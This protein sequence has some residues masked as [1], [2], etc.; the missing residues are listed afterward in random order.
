MP[1]MR[2]RLT[3]RTL[4][5]VIAAAG[6]L[7]GTGVEGLRLQRLSAVYANRA[8]E[9]ANRESAYA[10]AA[11]QRA[12]L[13]AESDRIVAEHDELI[14]TT[15]GPKRLLLVPGR[16]VFQGQSNRTRIDSERYAARAA[17]CARMKT[18]YT[19]AAARP[20]RAVAADPA[21]PS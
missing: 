15:P 20:W 5:A 4:M 13:A 18:K 12:A 8:K 17:W 16:V 21:E 10:R 7:L 19:A 9:F 11:R 6:T 2:P 14:R 3:I 1:G